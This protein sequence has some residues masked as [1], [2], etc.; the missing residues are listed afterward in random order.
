MLT[1]RWADWTGEVDAAYQRLAART[2]RI[3]VVGQSMGGS[4]AL[5][6]ALQHPEVARPRAAS[7]RRPSRSRADV[8]EMLGELLADGTDVVP[9]IGSDIADPDVDRDRLRRHAA[10][11]R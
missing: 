3:V 2:E 7:T 4:L 11:R 1:T 10:A 5:W 6:T 9:G 8:R